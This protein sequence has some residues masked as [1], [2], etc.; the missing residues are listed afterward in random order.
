MTFE[1]EADLF[2]HIALRGLAVENPERLTGGRSN[3]VWRA[4]PVVIKLYQGSDEN[5]LF[6]NDALRERAS[7]KA[8]ARTGMAP[9]LLDAGTFRGCKWLAYSH[10]E[11][12]AWQKD[13]AHVAQLLGRLH[14]HIS[15]SGLP[16]GRNGSAELS[17]QTLAILAQCNNSNPLRGLAPSGQV[18]A[19][20]NLVVIHGDPVPGNLVEHTGTLTLI[21]WQCPQIG[22]PAEDLALFLSPAMQLLYRGKPLAQ[23]E[24]VA[25]LGAYPD[26]AVVARFL[27]LKPWFHWRMAA[28]C[29]WRLE[30]GGRRDRDAMA[31]ELDALQSISPSAA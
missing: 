29:L 6:A 11:G 12:S 21:D 7:L 18:A 15:F 17:D 4:G 14:D 20:A 10:I 26:R 1:F 25:F 13:S 28:Y 22:D 3:H 8:L 19:L 24:E 5:P 27:A 23:D 31:L 9:Q 16:K 30:R 2:A